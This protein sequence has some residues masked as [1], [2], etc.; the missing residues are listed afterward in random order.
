M[1]KVWVAKVDIHYKTTRT[2]PIGVFSSK[3]KAKACMEKLIRKKIEGAS[4]LNQ[5][6]AKE[7]FDFGGTLNVAFQCD[8]VSYQFYAERLE[9]L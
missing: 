2:Q 6:K 8:D 3:A 5:K 1:A 4:M 7:W 9:V